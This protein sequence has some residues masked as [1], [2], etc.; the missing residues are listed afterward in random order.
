M[1]RALEHITSGSDLP[2]M[3]ANFSSPL[4][5]ITANGGVSSTTP[6]FTVPEELKKTDLA[7]A[8]GLPANRSA[9]SYVVSEIKPPPSGGT[10]FT[11]TVAPTGE[12]AGGATQYLVPNRT[13]W[14]DPEPVGTIANGSATG[15]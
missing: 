9:P 5:K 4:V 15:E 1:Q 3:Q 6:Y 2:V 11:S 7:N 12:S 14:S 13:G 10:V 8:F